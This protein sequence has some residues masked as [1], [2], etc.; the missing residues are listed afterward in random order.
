MCAMGHVL[1]PAMSIFILCAEPEIAE[2]TAKARMNAMRTGFRPKADT[3]LPIRG[4]T[5]VDAIV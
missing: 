2:P 5:A 1:L 4:S 3:K